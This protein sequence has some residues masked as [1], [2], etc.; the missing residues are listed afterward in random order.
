MRIQ[1]RRPVLV[2]AL[3]TLAAS[4]LMA[5]RRPAAR[6]RPAA[7]APGP[8]LG[9]HLGFNFDAEEALLGAQ[10]VFPIAPAFDLYPSFDFYLVS[11]YTLWGLN[12]D[13]RYRPPT[14]YGLLYLGGG[15]NYLRASSN[16]FGG[17]NTNLNILGGVEARRRRAAPYGELRL[18]VGDGSSFQIVGGVSWRL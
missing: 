1:W 12:L 8:R 9:P 7:T 18:T 14:R 4:P 11:G 17:S 13:V 10:A 16:G 6:T 15:L 2:A 5:Q 3:A